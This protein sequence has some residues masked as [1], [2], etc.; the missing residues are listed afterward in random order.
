MGQNIEKYKPSNGTEGE[1]F[2]DKFCRQCEHDDAYNS[3][4]QGERLCNIIALTLSYNVDDPE[5]PEEW[6][7]ENGKPTCTKFSQYPKTKGE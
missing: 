2:M 7:Y 5:Y 1:I 3:R 6:I 4:G